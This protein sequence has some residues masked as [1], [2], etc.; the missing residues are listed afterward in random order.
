MMEKEKVAGKQVGLYVNQKFCM[1]CK[2]CQIACKDKH[3]NELGVNFLQVKEFSGGGFARR[4]DGVVPEVWAYWVPTACRHCDRPG[5]ALRCPVGAIT[6]SAAD[7]TISIDQELCTGCRAC[8]KGC[9]YGA[10]QYSERK[11]KVL[12]CDLCADYRA[13]GKDPACVAACPMRVLEWG[14]VEE[15]KK[16][17]PQ[18]VTELQGL[19]DSCITRPN[20]LYEPHRHAVRKVPG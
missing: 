8:E 5:C 19:P 1:G 13:A 9:P 10:L 2:T 14:L 12:G 4:G 17:H 16:Q 11:R 7:G 15:L 20:T 6:K 18:A 3:D